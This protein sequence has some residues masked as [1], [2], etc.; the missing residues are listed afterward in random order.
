MTEPKERRSC[1]DLMNEGVKELDRGEF[2]RAVATL[3]TASSIDPTY[4]GPFFNLGLA[5]KA[6]GD[7]SSA[8]DA[9]LKAWRL[10]P[11]KASA[12][13][14]CSILWNIAITASIIGDW[15]RARWAWNLLGHNVTAF[16][17]GPPSIPMG[18]AWVSR[19]G[20]PPVLGSR[21]DPVRVRI[22]AAEPGDALLKPGTVVVHDGERMGSKPH[23]GK[24]LPI[25][26]VLAV[27][28]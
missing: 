21:L 4:F 6:L 27:I 1:G 22:L 2:T 10:L 5:Q 24:D 18:S 14:Y 16:D 28:I 13:I 8:F 7:W 12:E 26:P 25:F 19:S 9:F 11:T 15:S 17:P 3:Q 23:D 20:L